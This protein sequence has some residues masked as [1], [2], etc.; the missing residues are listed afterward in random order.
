M[1]K[2]LFMHGGSGNHGCEAIVRTTSKLLGGPKE[3]LLWS[4][5]SHEDEQYGT[6]KTVERVYR[7]EEMKRGSLAHIEALIRRKL[8]KQ[9][10]AN[11]QVFVR[12]LFKNSVAISVGGDNYC[13]PNWHRQTVFHKTAKARGAK[14]IL[15]GCSIEPEAMEQE[16]WTFE[17]RLSE[18]GALTLSLR[19]ETPKEDSE[20]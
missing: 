15:W 18:D 16:N 17:P 3:L 19:R 13:Y 7:S 5:N 2:V 11:L 20:S 12:N 10:D 1:K 4:F 9:S 8:L 6:A 14:S